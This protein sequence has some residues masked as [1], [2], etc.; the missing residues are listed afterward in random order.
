M[1]FDIKTQI[2]KSQTRF[3]FR[4]AWGYSKHFLL[5]NIFICRSKQVQFHVL[6][7]TVLCVIFTDRRDKG[8]GVFQ[9]LYSRI[10]YRGIY[11]RS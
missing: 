9:L 6:S 4:R 3:E 7:T 10:S 2:S 5:V 8:N 1:L 11:F